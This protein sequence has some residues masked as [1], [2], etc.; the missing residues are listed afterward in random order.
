MK[1]PDSWLR[2]WVDTPA[3]PNQLAERLTM[4]GHEVDGI[5]VAG[6]GLEGVLVAE[7]VE[8][9]PHPDADRLSVCRVSDGSGEVHG[10]VC[11]AP[12]VMA[13]M[14]SVLALPGA[15]LPDGTRLRRTKIRGV[16]SAG[17]LCSA[18][19]LGLGDDAD[20]IL[21][22]ADDAPAGVPLAAYL[23][24]PDR[25]YELNL[26]PNRGDCFSMLGM[27]RDIA[28]LT[29]A[30]LRDA[31]SATV[32]V[33]I[34]AEQPV[35]LD[36]PEA[37]PR[38]AGR[39]IK[40]I[41][42]AARTPLWMTERLRRCG[43]RAIHPV[44]D[45]T[46]YVMLELGQPLHAYDVD[47]L[48]GTIRPRF[49]RAGERLT[50]LDER[51]VELSPDTVLVTDDSGPIGLAGIMGGLGTAVS[52]STTNVFF[53]A[54][55]WPQAVIAG[56][57]R[58][59]GLHT[60]ASLRFE[61]GVDPTGQAR[62]IER[63]TALLL[64]IA[65]GGAGALTDLCH[66][67]SLPERG[68]FVL[69]RA[70]L[71]S[72]LGMELDRAEVTRILQSL[73]LTVSETDEGWLAKAPAF[74]FDLAIED[75]LVEEVARV[76]GYDRIPETTEIASLPLGSV[77]ER[78]VD[79]ERIAD[80]LVARDYQQVVTYSF[81]DAATDRL[82]TG[83]ESGL[84]LSNPISSEMAVMRGSLWPGML[85]V[86]ASNLARQQERIRLFEC[87][88]TF[89]GALANPDEV[90]R[91]A[92]LAIGAA[93]PEQWG[94]KAREVDFFDVKAD[95]QALL[96]LT[97]AEGEIAFVQADHPALQAG[98]S[99]QILRGGRLIG[100]AGK[101]HPSTARA[102]AISRPV[103]VFELDAA[104]AFTANIP[105]AAA[106]SRFPAI[107]RDVAVVV[108]DDIT[109]AELIQVA[110][111]AAPDIIRRAVVF[112]VYRGP[113]I[114]AGLKSVALGLILQ[115]TSRTLTDVDADAAMSKAVQKLQQECS[116]VLRE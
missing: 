7:V 35:T 41:N 26:T 25:I 113:G 97:G 73:G 114:E 78:R 100:V 105:V 106:V 99:A 65:G 8:V 53:E 82:F 9:A 57:A 32:A 72:L 112:D 90:L 98:Q 39:M 5:E 67:G 27:A 20:G 43:I 2:A 46:N 107:R 51:E 110:L 24:L 44:V 94:T 14:K 108:A 28:A 36:D 1:F 76:F 15:T 59:Y 45:V 42:A 10:I 50:L 115:E 23:D 77:T 18:R 55:F 92:G 52:R 93:E 3:D 75:D 34:D 38:F 91:L 11:G 87:G 84:V 22:L 21:R 30:S 86:A 58:S 81:I 74:R 31:R 6:Q 29:G 71:H 47:R 54:A 85:R 66:P 116:A 79:A 13:G 101:L 103:Q 48:S 89:H 104:A 61:R 80:T 102:L 49:A 17:M 69:R 19:E 56:R 40:G 62:A 111:S 12:N 33:T 60:D 70:R 88:K 96:D 63:A 109:S 95:L 4:A 68:S 64:D 37:C 83:R 16:E